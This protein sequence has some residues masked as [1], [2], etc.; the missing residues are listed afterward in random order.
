MTT[1]EMG[2]DTVF[3]YLNLKI[4]SI[5][6]AAAFWH[7]LKD[8]GDDEYFTRHA[9]CPVLLGDKWVANKWMHEHGQEFRR[10][11]SPQNFIEAIETDLFRDFF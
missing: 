3:P 9:S 4:P 7:N 5:K 1:V 6:G 10:P 11:C 2:G 8:S